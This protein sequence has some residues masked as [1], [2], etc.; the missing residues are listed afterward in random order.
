MRRSN[1]GLL[2]E[3]VYRHL[4]DAIINGDFE[5]GER[6]RDVDLAA[7]LEVSRTPVREALRR[8]EDEGL[9][10]T[11]ANR[12]TRVSPL[13]LSEGERIYPIIWTLERLAL[14]QVDSF[15]D[16]RLQK[17]IDANA[18]LQEGLRAQDPVTASEADREFHQELVEAAGNPEIVRILDEL[19]VRLRRLE[20]QYFGGS[21]PA[22]RSV[23]EHQAVIDA[24]ANGDPD[25]AGRAIEE[26][27]RNSL[28]R[29]RPRSD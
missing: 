5:P 9:I 7:D 2:R 29:L 1:R 24:L 22:E 3:D 25:A 14:S 16:E 21:L 26:N 6:L 17:L 15:P 13:D 4:R 28:Q 27:W 19:K 18:R 12:W 10:E 20:I 8:L 11:W 23:D